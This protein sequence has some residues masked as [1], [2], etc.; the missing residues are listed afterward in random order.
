MEI[1]K[2]IKH[3]NNL[4][5]ITNS[6]PVIS[7]LMSTG[8]QIFCTGGSIGSIDMNMTG[9]FALDALKN[10][11]VDT[12]F[13]TATWHHSANRSH[14]LHP[15]RRSFRETDQSTGKSDGFGNGQQ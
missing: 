6:L 7:E 11:H 15:G 1:A 14:L 12:A 8:I 3:L 2:T 9:P 13:V 10:F 4:T 5:V